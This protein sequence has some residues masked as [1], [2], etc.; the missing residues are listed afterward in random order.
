MADATLGPERRRRPD[1][2]FDR[3]ARVLR[4]LV[5][6]LADVRVLHAERLP[7]HG[8]VVVAANH[9]CRRDPL[10]V[11]VVVSRL[12][13]RVRFL[14]VEGLFDVPFVGRVLRATRMIP[15]RRGGGAERMVA[16]ARWALA[17]GEAIVVYPEGTI[18]EPG[19]TLVGRPGAGLL[20]LE[21]AVWQAPVI[22]VA[23]WGLDHTGRS[24]LRRLGRRRATVVVGTP[25][26]VS[27]WA[28]RR[29]RGAQLEVSAAMLDA[30]R[31][32]LPE[33]ERA[34]RGA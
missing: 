10:V 15:V 34:T 19:D 33:A 9:V 24:L 2:W 21:A 20:A 3:V 23:S 31:A 17:A 32:L 6:F 8:P 25:V 5:W 12:R 11:G 18:P 13:G 7:R 27:A 4:V 22:P 14:A 1:P 29:D 30:V 26:D 28:G 16:D